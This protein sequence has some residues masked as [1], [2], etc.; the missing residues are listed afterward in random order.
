LIFFLSACS[1]GSLPPATPTP[2]LAPDKGRV[3]GI[4]QVR[5]GETKKPV[6]NVNLYLGATV[7]DSTG[8]DS[9]V[10]FDRLHDPR[11]I[12]D[13]KGHFAFQNVTPGNYGLIFDNGFNS[14]FLNKPNT[15][16]GYLVS[17]ETG[18]EIDLGTLVYDSLP[19]LP[20][21]KPYPYP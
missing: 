1:S 15:E 19:L 6:S 12:T 3:I 13:D 18:K 14:Y 5:E 11:A 17:V 2:T 8:K 9:Y 7:K 20:T 21:P 10:G 16:E 4:L